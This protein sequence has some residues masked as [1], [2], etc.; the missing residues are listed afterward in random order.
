M[1]T[2]QMIKLM[3]VSGAIVFGVSS[4]KKNLLDPV[5]DGSDI[6]YDNYVHE[7][8]TS[9]CSGSS[10]HSSGSGNGT[11]TNYANIQGIINNGKFKSEVLTN[12]TM[13]ENSSLSQDELN[14]IQ[15]WVDNG[16]P[17]N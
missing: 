2:S 3:L 12:Q 4:C 8:I 1:N 11:Y 17:E 10:C 14:K 6:T 15:C 13:P 7:I 16:Y 5:C 9:K